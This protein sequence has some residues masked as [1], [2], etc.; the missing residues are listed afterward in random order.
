MHE[1]AV[2]YKF[3]GGMFQWQISHLQR[4]NATHLDASLATDGKQCTEE[5]D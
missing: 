2:Y 3:V 4:D 5:L 1:T